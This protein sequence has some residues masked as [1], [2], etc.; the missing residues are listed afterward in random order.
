MNPSPEQIAFCSWSVQPRRPEDLVRACQEVEIPRVQLA[1]NP[2]IDN[3]ALWGDVGEF[4]ASE[5]ISV[6]SGMFAAAGE[7]YSTPETIRRTGGIVPDETWNRNRAMVE[8]S[9][10]LAKRFG[11]ETIT[12]HIGFIPEEPDDP[13]FSVVVERTREI[14]DCFG[15]VFEG[16]L[17][18]ETGQE[19]ASTLAGFL[20]AVERPNVFV[21]FDPANLLLYDM[22][23][24]MEA[25]R[26]LSSSLGG[27]HL[28]DARRGWG[29]ETRVGDG[30]V[31]W[32]D[33]FNH[34]REIEYAGP[35]V[36][37][38][39]GGTQRVADI[40]HARAFTQSML[41]KLGSE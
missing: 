21:N 25:L 33:F 9:A 14:A 8:A 10:H 29:Q 16:A 40:R 15:K 41:E 2:L 4:L 37:E 24:P 5:G 20:K 22:G 32:E 7:D 12:T 23:D 13:K 28:K 31:P 17:C 35:L 18:L 30:E 1:L 6:I 36:I 26:E 27:I 19:S 11:F 38:R 3:A 34:L 39:E